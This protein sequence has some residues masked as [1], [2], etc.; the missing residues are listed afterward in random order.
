MTKKDIKQAM[1]NAA[2]NLKDAAVA[3]GEVIA[4]TTKEAAA[5]V[6]EK[7]KM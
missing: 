6:K 2:A 3:T 7:P 4:E 1:E 5:Y